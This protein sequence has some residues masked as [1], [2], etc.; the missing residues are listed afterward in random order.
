MFNVIISCSLLKSLHAISISQ[1]TDKSKSRVI[2]L[3]PSVMDR[4]FILSDTFNQFSMNPFF[5]FFPIIS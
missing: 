5:F 3:S 4:W 1:V 2:L